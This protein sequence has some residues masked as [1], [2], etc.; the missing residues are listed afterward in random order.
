MAT[1]RR[2]NPDTLLVVAM[3]AAAI[4]LIVLGWRLTF[5]QDTFEV[6]IGRQPWNAHSLL[7]PHNEHLIV[8]QA[9]VEKGLVEIF[10][11]GNA[12]PEMLFMTATLLLSAG[13][14]YVYVKRRLAV[15][16]RS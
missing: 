15:G 10:G 2:T 7:A 9:I 8:L 3:A 11:M 13:L 4:L 16:W 6:L 1:R 14:V 5:F 12:R